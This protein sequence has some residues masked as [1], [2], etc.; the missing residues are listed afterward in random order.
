MEEKLRE[1][2]AINDFRTVDATDEEVCRAVDFV[3]CT[4]HR[5]LLILT[6]SCS[7]RLSS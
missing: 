4:G 1:Y 7:D 2:S 6:G 5:I 3:I